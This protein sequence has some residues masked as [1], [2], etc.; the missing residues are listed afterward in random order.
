MHHAYITARARSLDMT[1]F[2]RPAGSKQ[3]RSNSQRG[4]RTRLQKLQARIKTLPVL[5]FSVLQ[6]LRELAARIAMASQEPSENVEIEVEVIVAEPSPDPVRPS[7]LPLPFLHDVRKLGR[8]AST[9]AQ[10][11][12]EPA[13]RRGRERRGGSPH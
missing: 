1:S 8:P 10:S 13:P 6:P 11:E 3:S 4:T 5:A 2:G 7:R 9:G 12:R